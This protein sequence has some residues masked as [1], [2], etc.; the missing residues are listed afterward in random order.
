MGP[1]VATQVLL[2]SKF[3]REFNV[4]HIDTADRRSLKKI[5]KWDITNVGLALKQYGQ[6]FW[7][8]VSIRSDLVYIPISQTAR[9]FLRDIPF[10]WLAKIYRKKAVLHL[11]GGYFRE[12]YNSSHRLMKFIIRKTLKKIDR[13]I[14]LGQSLKPMFTGL[15]PEEKISVVP[16]G[17]DYGT[18]SDFGEDRGQKADGPQREYSVLFLSNLAKSKGYEDVL[19]SLPIVVK[20]REH[21]RYIFAGEWTNDEDSDGYED[22]VRQNKLEARA[23]V[24]G[25]QTGENK[26]RLYREADLFVFP[27]YYPFEGHPW[28][29]IEAMAA[30]LPIITTDQGCI[31]ESVT[32]GD[33]GF[34][35]PKRNPEA[36]AEKILYLL[37]HPEV[38][39]RMGR[40][41]RELYEANFTEEHFVNGMIGV[42]KQA[43]K[44]M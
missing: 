22:F 41:S 42:F 3:V 27:T 29:I 19:R 17:L 9:G 39:E 44:D 14:V 8:L 13:M 6:L 4:V 35:I 24:L 16:N 25:V 5:G 11:R 26:K 7:K 33:N 21:V 10:V 34:I 43:L 40:R 32:D 36:I 2:H 30:G 23:A 28:V 15:I 20:R 37:D 12:F 31:R 38:R 18:G 1:S